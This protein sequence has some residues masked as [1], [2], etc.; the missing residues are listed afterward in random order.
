MILQ[1]KEKKRYQYTKKTGRPAKFDTPEKM[2]EAIDNYFRKCPDKRN[3]TTLTG[4]TTLPCPTI[5]GLVMHLGFCDRQSF[6]AYEKKEKFSYT[7][8]K[9]RTKIEQVYETLLRQSACTGAIFALKNLGWK[10]T[11]EPLVDNSKHIH[12]TTN[13]DTSNMTKEQMLD[14][15]LRR[16]NYRRESQATG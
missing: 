9:A 5:T 7:I 16:N 2:Q 8:K 15:I 1:K 3:V 10:D 6:Y 11:K 12:Y 14:F 13:I 4:T